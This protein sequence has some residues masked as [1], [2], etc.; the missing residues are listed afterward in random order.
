MSR[1]ARPEIVL[2]PLD[3]AG[4]CTLEA[5]FQDAEL[6]SRL[7]GMFPLRRWNELARAEPGHL[8]WMA[9]EQDAAVGLVDLEASPHGAAWV[10]FL[11][12]PGLRERGYGARILRA[13]LSRPELSGLRQIKAIVDRTNV[14][15]LRC[16]WSVGFVVEWLEPDEEGFV[17][18]AYPLA[19]R[20]AA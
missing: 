17:I 20:K 11:V 7:G 10:T 19:D 14:A 8:T 12:N 9:Y 13:M 2:V 16:F 15:S 4:L 18:L 6:C 3:E 5:W 1:S